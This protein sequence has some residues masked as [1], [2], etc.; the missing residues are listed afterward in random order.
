MSTDIKGFARTLTL[1]DPAA[2]DALGA[3]IAAGLQAGDSIALEGDLGAGKTT[4][5]RAVLRALGVTGTVPSPTFTLVQH[6]ETRPPVS[7]YDLYRIADPLELDEL[8]MDDALIDG[9]ALIEWPDRAGDRLPP[10][11]LHLEL[12]STGLQSREVRLRG[13]V[14]W[15]NAFLEGKGSHAG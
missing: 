3:R 11:A 8:G 12:R 14:R 7:H 1:A 2:T 5:V 10:D 6:Y 13:P 4:L 15:A 9:C